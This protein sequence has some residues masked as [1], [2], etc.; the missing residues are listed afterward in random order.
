M[1]ASS[2]W[3]AGYVPGSSG[4]DQTLVMHWNGS[5]W[6]QVQVPS[7]GG[8]NFDHNLTGIVGAAGT[9]PPSIPSWKRAGS[10]S[11]AFRGAR[12]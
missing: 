5:F 11:T 7:P 12:L 3:A 1:S 8:S 2:V 9:S 6:A 4:K 10:S